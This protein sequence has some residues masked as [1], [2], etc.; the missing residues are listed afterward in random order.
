MAREKR[1]MT[2]GTEGEEL[3]GWVGGGAKRL[4]V[5]RGK[6]VAAAFLPP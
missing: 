2:G 3:E 6:A 4:K 1:R 5:G